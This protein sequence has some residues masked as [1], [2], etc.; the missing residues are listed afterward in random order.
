MMKTTHRLLTLLFSMV[1]FALSGCGTLNSSYET[2]KVDVVGIKKSAADASALQFT[3]QLRI[4]NPNS[5]TLKLG[6]LYY[7]LSLEG[8]EVITG[9]AN[10]LP[11]IAGYSDAV[12][13]VSSTASLIN[14]ARL[15]RRLIH[16]PQELLS[17]KLSAKLGSTSKWKPAT[18]ITQSG[19]IALQ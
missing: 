5:E 17:Y 15:I 18:T 12:I 9:T 19:Q 3:I 16:E 2:P 11:P 8:I 13:S 7:E 14:S 4:L 10:N 1:L 6:G